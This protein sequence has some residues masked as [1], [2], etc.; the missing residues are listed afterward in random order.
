[1]LVSVAGCGPGAPV[2]AVDRTVEGGVEIV[3]SIR[4]SWEAGAGW[5]V[6]AE[7]EVAIG[8]NTDELDHIFSS[9]GGPVS[10]SD[11][12]IVAGDYA[13]RELRFF[14]AEGRFLQSTG[15]QGEGPGELGVLADVLRC[16]DDTMFVLDGMRYEV[17][18][19][20]SEGEFGRR[21]PF[22]VNAGVSLLFPLR[23][24]DA[25]LLLGTDFGGQLVGERQTGF[26]RGRVHV[27]LLDPRGYA[28]Q[29]IGEFPGPELFEFNGRTSRHPFGRTISH[30]LGSDRVYVGTADEFEI[31]VWSLDASL[32]RRIRRPSDDAAVSRTDFD[33]YV[34]L[35]SA[36][37]S[38]DRLEEF[39]L[40]TNA[41]P[42]PDTFPAYE[43]FVLDAQENLWVRHFPRP[44]EAGVSWSV[45]DPTGVW[46]GELTLPARL[47]V[48]EI[49][50]DYVLGMFRDEL[51]DQSVRRYRLQR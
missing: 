20:T 2:S 43:G 13:T 12:R 31:Q 5:S 6:G 30:A 18:E 22:E 1:M 36:A 17:N 51:G 35:E 47:W 40:R 23:C 15:G 38:P 16:G 10:L 48:T 45:F 26:H 24:N 50:D 49:G 34:E 42:V 28:L 4:P 14:D 11:G 44:G 7:P 41:M 37:T 21:D 29:D 33:R 32:V 39:R 3:T 9:V 25:G 19:V 8:E 46:L 27:W